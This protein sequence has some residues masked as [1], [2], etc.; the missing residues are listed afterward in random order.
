MSS[1]DDGGHCRNTP[2]VIQNAFKGSV[3]WH[4]SFSKY[5]LTKHSLPAITL[6]AG[7]IKM[8]KTPN[9]PVSFG[10]SVYQGVTN[11]IKK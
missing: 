8:N 7:N 3:Q 1:A 5:L 6:R 9:I 11:E 4:Q 10:L 2:Q